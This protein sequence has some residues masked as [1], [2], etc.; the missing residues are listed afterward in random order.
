MDF[1]DRQLTFIFYSGSGTS[2][3]ATEK[4]NKLFKNAKIIDIKEPIKNKDELKKI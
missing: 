2:S 1:G 4:V 3:K